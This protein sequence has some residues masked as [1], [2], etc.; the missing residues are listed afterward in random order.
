MLHL[1]FHYTSAAGSD[2]QSFRD[3]LEMETRERFLNS[4]NETRIQA[5]FDM[6]KVYQQLNYDSAEKYLS[7]AQKFSV[8]QNDYSGLIKAWSL[9]G[10]Q[11]NNLGDEETS[12]EYFNKAVDLSIEKKDFKETVSLLLNLSNNYVTRF[13]YIKV[14]NILDSAKYF[15]DR[16]DLKEI[17]PNL[18]IRIASLYYSIG[19]Y[20]FS[21]FY[22]TKARDLLNEYYNPTYDIQQKLLQ[23]LIEFKHGNNLVTESMFKAS[24]TIAEQNSMPG[25]EILSYRRMSAFCMDTKDYEKA[26]QYIDRALKLTIEYGLQ[27]ERSNLLVY[28][29]H[30]ESLK[31]NYDST[32]KYNLLAFNLRKRVGHM[33]VITSSYI[34]LGGNYTRLKKYDLAEEYI[35]KGLELSH[36]LGLTRYVAVGN[37]KLSELY[38]EKGDYKKALHF[39]KLEQEYYDSFNQAINKEKINFFSD[40]TST[41][42]AK[43]EEA[44]NTLKEKSQ[45]IIYLTILV[46]LLVGLILVLIAVIRYR[47]KAGK[48]IRR[49]SKVIETTNQGVVIINRN[50]EITYINQ[51]AGRIIGYDSN[52]ELMGK[53]VK[54]FV[55]PGSSEFVNNE[56]FE[57]F[58]HD[59]NWSGEIDYISKSGAKRTAYLTTSFLNDKKS[60]EISIVGVFTDIT[61][62]KKNQKELSDSKEIL[63]RTVDTQETMFSILAHDLV[64]PFN[65][66]LGFTNELA[67]NYSSY[68]DDQISKFSRIIN[69]SSR[70]TYNLL[71]NLLH[72]SRSKF[73]KIKIT[74][75]SFK[76]NEILVQNIK[77]LSYNS[78][79]KNITLTN[80]VDDEFTIYA[81][82]QS[83]D[84]VIRNLLSNAIKFTPDKG[85]V[86]ISA[87]MSNNDQIIEISDTG[88]GIKPDDIKHLFTTGGIQSTPGTNE[89]KGT[90]LGL[91][92]CHDLIKLNNGEIKAQSTVGKGTTFTIVLPIDRS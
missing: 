83:L 50:G 75:S 63:Q 38:E 9:F 72:W 27:I 40:I 54:S 74:K 30:I 44:G 31:E 56:L 45:N 87:K 84:V 21:Q 59:A 58:A 1:L 17:E 47:R 77:L 64:S 36:K 66:I 49:L 78:D 33:L 10:I 23:G 37:G 67:E 53:N 39:S 20:N 92:L 65:T 8:E 4:D 82:K 62:L 3:S 13:Q 61:E 42:M 32:L 90:G 46:V 91:T 12:L 26:N 19:D 28:K 51:G 88:V 85:L 16:Y 76:L 15:I 60:K 18:Y 55:A 69:E 14:Y 29:A 81:D 70:Q 73:G 80:N 86:T 41:E 43:L 11:Y 89:E 48:E 52:K 68:S 25:M 2:Y 5:C 71:N 79:K 7:L 34:N 6:Y 35:I 57:S 22:L 24:L